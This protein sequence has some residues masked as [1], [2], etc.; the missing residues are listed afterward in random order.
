MLATAFSKNSQASWSAL[1]SWISARISSNSYN[2]K[3]SVSLVDASGVRAEEALSSSGAG[4]S[5]EGG[6]RELQGRRGDGD[7]LGGGVSFGGVVRVDGFFLQWDGLLARA[8][9]FSSADEGDPSS[10]G[11][12]LGEWWSAPESLAVQLAAWKGAQGQSSSGH[13]RAGEI[14]EDRWSVSLILIGQI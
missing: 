1:F 5:S 11:M 3:S 7:G 13:F 9:G 6:M 4:V 2:G 10:G 14:G 8:R 12:W